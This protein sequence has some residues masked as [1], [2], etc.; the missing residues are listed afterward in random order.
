MVKK[1]FDL[2]DHSGIEKKSMEKIIA[3]YIESKIAQQGSDPTELYEFSL[4]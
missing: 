2:A 1:I 4:I 3:F